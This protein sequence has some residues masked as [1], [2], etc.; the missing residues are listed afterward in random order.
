MKSGRAKRKQ[1][2]VLPIRISFGK[3]AET[4]G[5]YYNVGKLPEFRGKTSCGGGAFLIAVEE[6]KKK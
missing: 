3:I 4:V 2:S 1:K 5:I 6:R